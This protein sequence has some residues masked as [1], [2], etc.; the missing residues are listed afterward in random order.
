MMGYCYEVPKATHFVCVVL[1]IDSVCEFIFGDFF[2]FNARILPERMLPEGQDATYLV[3]MY[4]S[5]N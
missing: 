5:N 2:F 4:I 3:H 1:N